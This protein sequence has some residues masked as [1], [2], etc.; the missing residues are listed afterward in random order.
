MEKPSPQEYDHANDLPNEDRRRPCR[1]FKGIRLREWGKWVS[2]IRMPKSREK[3][4]LG[5]YNTAEQAARAFDFAMYYLRGSNAKLNFPDSVPAIPSSSYL[6][7]QQIRAAAAKYALNELPSTSPSLHQEPSQ[8]SSV[9]EIELSSDDKQKSEELA[10]WQSLF[11]GSDGD[12]YL[13][14][15]KIPSIDEA[16]ALEIIPT[17]Q[18]EEVDISVDEIGLWNFED[19]FL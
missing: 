6:S 3:I 5:S 12:G 1:Q 2:E 15:E 7:P 14:L 17:L 9:S 11:A 16:M 13:N 10:F 8:S 18:E 19:V 4:Y